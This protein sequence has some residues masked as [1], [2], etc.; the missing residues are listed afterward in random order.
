MKRKKPEADGAA[1]H[2]WRK[3]AKAHEHHLKLLRD[4]W[5][6]VIKRQADEA[7]RLT[8]FLGDHHDITVL[9]SHL[10]QTPEAFG[11]SAAAGAI[12]ALGEARQAVLAED[13]RRLGARLFAEKPGAFG[14]RYERYFKA[15]RREGRREDAAPGRAA[16]A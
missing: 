3:H 13:A 14:R 2:E 12:L 7:N 1:M 6:R 15:W 10:E 16:A 9:L 4:T 8:E 11:G 5:P